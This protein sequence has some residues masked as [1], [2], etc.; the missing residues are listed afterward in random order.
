MYSWAGDGKLCV[1]AVLN[2]LGECF[3]I[4]GVLIKEDL[5][6]ADRRI[7]IAV[8]V[9]ADGQERLFPGNVAT[10]RCIS[11]AFLWEESAS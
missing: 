1:Q 9:D 3:S 11:C 6:A 4:G 2:T 8:L 5:R 7:L 10:R